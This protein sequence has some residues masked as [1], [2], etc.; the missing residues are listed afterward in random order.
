MVRRRRGRSLEL[1]EVEICL[2][3]LWQAKKGF[4]NHPLFRRRILR[5]LGHIR[6][7]QHDYPP[8]PYSL[9]T[10]FDPQ[11]PLDHRDRHGKPRAWSKRNWRAGNRLRGLTKLTDYPME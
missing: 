6:S 5:A 10:A 1:K 3:S 2:D 9:V 7:L 4:R 8:P 11:Q